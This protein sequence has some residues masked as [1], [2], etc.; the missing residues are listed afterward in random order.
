MADEL[1]TKEA[2][3]EKAADEELSERLSRAEEYGKWSKFGHV[4]KA[5]I[6]PLF[7]LLFPFKVKGRENI[8]TDDRPLIVCCNHISMVDPVFLLLAQKQEDIYFMGK[9]ELF[10]SGFLA[11]LLGKQWGSFPVSRGK[12][13]MNALALAEQLIAERK[14]MGIFPEGT[15]SKTGELGRFKSGAALLAAK[16]QA[17]VLPVSVT[18]KNQKVKAFRRV[19]VS[20]GAPLSPTELELCGEKP[21]LRVA[22]RAMT[23][24]V[25]ALM[26]DAK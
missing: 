17:Y 13:D 14:W 3:R 9:E 26:E 6:R 12:G 8:P 1:T 15:R 21:N 16:T 5:I 23:A 7:H 20:F 11:W 25:S 2:E 22:T 4:L 10:R 19:T 18:T 24:A